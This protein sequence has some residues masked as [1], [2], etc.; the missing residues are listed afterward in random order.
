MKPNKAVWILLSSAVL[1]C[2]CQSYSSLAKGEPV[3]DDKDARF[4]LRDGWLLEADAGSHSRIEGG[5]QVSGTLV[6]EDTL[7]ATMVRGVRKTVKPFTGVVRDADIE[8]INA[9]QFD[10]AT[11]VLV[12]ALPVSMVILLAGSVKFGL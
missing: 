1:F 11:T 9:Y 7:Q 8:E 2:G 5:Y 3:S 4:Q 12:V 10:A 6:K